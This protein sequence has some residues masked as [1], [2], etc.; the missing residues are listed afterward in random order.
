M[1]KS[2]KKG[3][4]TTNDSSKKLTVILPMIL[5]AAILSF[6]ACN[7]DEVLNPQN[8]NP[9]PD[10]FASYFKSEDGFQSSDFLNELS[11]GSITKI[12]YITFDYITIIYELNEKLTKGDEVYFDV[13]H[14]HIDAY[15]PDSIHSFYWKLLV[16]KDT[17]INGVFLFYYTAMYD[18]TPYNH[19]NFPTNK[20]DWIPAGPL[21]YLIQKD[22]D[23]H[24]FQVLGDG[25][26]EP[27]L[28]WSKQERDGYFRDIKITRK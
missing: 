21:R 7:K 18:H 16:K 22:G 11:S 13:T 14:M 25:L 4:A 19:T 5:A 23:L 15:N 10:S 3:T 20:K 27:H 12:E 17:E 24:M 9:I 26:P 2:P 1:K 6:T 8:P 28:N